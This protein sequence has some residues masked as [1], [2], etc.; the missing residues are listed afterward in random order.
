MSTNTVMV[1]DS[2]H[3]SMTHAK[4]T[5]AST[6]KTIVHTRRNPQRLVPVFIEFGWILDCTI[7]AYECTCRAIGPSRENM[8]S[9]VKSEA[10]NVSQRRTQ[11][12]TSRR[13][14]AQKFGDVW[15]YGFRVMRADR[16]TYKSYGTMRHV[17][18]GN[19]T[20]IGEILHIFPLGSGTD[21]M[22]DRGSKKAYTGS[23]TG[24][25][26]PTKF[27]CDRSIVVGCRS[28]NDRQT[29]RQTDRQNGMTITLTLCERNAIT[30]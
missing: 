28:R 12:R 19:N 8:T 22:G 30:V 13:Q 10:H 25:Y 9:S 16:Q 4:Y 11:R 17:R 15:P 20:R 27:G 1:T 23:R 14:L 29:S 6:H 2:V 26:L 3:M 5:P 24:I 21:S 7:A 18:S